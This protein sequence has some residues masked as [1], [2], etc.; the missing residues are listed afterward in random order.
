MITILKKLMPWGPVFFGLFIMAP[1]IDQVLTDA[2]L[3]P[4]M[5]ISNLQIGIAMGLVWGLIAKIGGRWI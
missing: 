1:L 2:G 5:N 3:I 4:A